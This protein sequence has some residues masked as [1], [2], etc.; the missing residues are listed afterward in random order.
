MSI[1]FSAAAHAAGVL[2]IFPSFA[3]GNKL[4]FKAEYAC[5]SC[6]GHLKEGNVS[7]S[8]EY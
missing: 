2:G 3:T 8:P 7:V 4:S 6:C 1:L 5:F